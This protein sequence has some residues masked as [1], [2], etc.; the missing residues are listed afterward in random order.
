[1]SDKKL[2]NTHNMI[3]KALTKAVSGGKHSITAIGLNW[4]M[5]TKI[6]GRWFSSLH[7]IC[8]WEERDNREQAFMEAEQK[9]KRKINV[10]S[11]IHESQTLLVCCNKQ[12]VWASA[13]FYAAGSA[14]VYMWI[15]RLAFN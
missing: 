12:F 2:Q 6:I 3:Q 8:K 1:M 5:V 7:I 4:R 10:W 14:F 13:T 11:Q 15:Q 9:F